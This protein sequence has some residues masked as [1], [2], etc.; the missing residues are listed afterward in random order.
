MALTKRYE[1][2][3]NS[4]AGVAYR[5]EL[6]Q[7]GYAGTVGNIAFSDTPLTIEWAKTDK[8]EPVQSSSATLRLYSDTDRQFLDLYTIKAGAVRMDVYRDNALYWSGTLDPELYEEPYSY[9]Q[10]YTVELTFGDFAL[11]DREK[12]SERGFV[13]MAGVL[14]AALAKTGIR[15]TGI[16]RYISTRL[17][18]TEESLPDRVCVS[19]MNFFDEDD[20]P[21]TYREVLDEVLRPF[22]LRLIQK[23]G[24]VVLYDL[25]AIYTA[26]KS[27]DL[28]WSSD[29]A[30][31]G[32]DKVYNNVTI[33]FSPYGQSQLADEEVTGIGSGST[34]RYPLRP[35][36]PEP[37]GFDLTLSDTGEG[38]GK[39]SWA[40]YFKMATILS[41]S[42]GNG[43]AQRVVYSRTGTNP[44]TLVDD[45]ARTGTV[46]SLPKRIFL[47][48]SGAN[49]RYMLRLSVDLLIDDRL[50]P[51]DEDTQ[52]DLLGQSQ[53]GDLL[54][55]R[56]KIWYQGC[57]LSLYP[58]ATG[59]SP[60]YS[61]RNLMFDTASTEPYCRDG[62]EWE[63]GEGSDKMCLC[64]YE[65][66][67]RENS[68]AL[69]GW[70]TNKQP[71]W[72]YWDSL[73]YVWRL[74]GDGEFIPMPP[75]GGYL[76]FSVSA[77]GFATDRVGM[78]IAAPPVF[79][80]TALY[81]LW[82][83]Y[84]YVKLE[85]V[86]KS[87]YQTVPEEDIE[88]TAWLNP[89][90][91]EELEVKTIVGCL[92]TASPTAKGQIFDATDKS[93]VSVFCRNNVWD[94]LEKLLIG[95]IYSNYATRHHTLSGETDILPTF[96]TYSD[97]NLPGVYLLLEETQDLEADTSSVLAVE[98]NQ[99]EYQGA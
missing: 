62:G 88:T 93:V 80:Y 9:K 25:N 5:V 19:G 27:A 26:F 78:D 10:D 69:K 36:D 11:L 18:R 37:L 15:H 23:G 56:A 30:V 72:Y 13:S 81:R 54:S 42:D 16:E 2:G 90:A 24:K 68:C 87:T 40:K 67:E 89:D 58:E 47:C 53:T 77:E 43:V 73:P 98:I 91:K 76:D 31:L 99:D 34:Y 92:E 32:T 17:S 57:R 86:D 59:G 20:E 64:Y 55:D 12:W 94:R 22:G 28:P 21:M 48:N 71:I 84:R 50:N 70:K 33:T 41:G 1:G 60:S 38:L 46:L 14:V 49:S 85:L 82:H 63:A 74:R 44:T 29:D 79:P 4:V 96:A 8:L 39:A 65:Q 83:L 95:T 66:E 51:F 52:A 6:W 35:E 61:Y 7:E 97:K 75:A 45:A 3:F